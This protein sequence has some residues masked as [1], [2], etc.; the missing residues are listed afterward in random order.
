MYRP[1]PLA[2]RW[3]IPDTTKPRPTTS[4]PTFKA[5]L[6]QQRYRNDPVGDL[7]RD[8]CLRPYPTDPRQPFYGTP[9]QQDYARWRG[10]LGVMGACAGAEAALDR[11]YTEFAATL[12]LV[13]RV[14]DEMDEDE[15]EA[16]GWEWTC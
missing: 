13:I 12:G 7:A 2:N 4:L 6:R 10:Y 15:E 1:R 11:A 8:A 3:G 14:G 5:W 9:G 16:A